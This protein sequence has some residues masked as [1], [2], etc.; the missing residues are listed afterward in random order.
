V[1]VAAG[2]RYGALSEILPPGLE[3]FN[4][5]KKL[6]NAMIPISFGSIPAKVLSW[7]DKFLYGRLRF[8]AGN[9]DRCRV[10]LGALAAELNV[11]EDSVAR[12]ID[13]YRKPV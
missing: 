4:G 6:H 13:G 5:Y 10:G 9:S 1:L 11:S 7:F 2:W 12:S 8:E 3:P